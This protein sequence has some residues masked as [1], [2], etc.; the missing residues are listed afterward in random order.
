MGIMDRSSEVQRDLEQ[1]LA[2]ARKR[3]DQ[4][5]EF[6]VLQFPTGFGSSL[7]RQRR[8]DG[9]LE[10]LASL[11]IEVAGVQ[12]QPWE[13]RWTIN[14]HNPRHTPHAFAAGHSG[15]VGAFCGSCG[16]PAL[17]GGQ[18]C[19]SCGAKLEDI[20]DANSNSDGSDVPR[21]ATVRRPTGRLLVTRRK[22]LSGSLF[23]FSV[24]IDGDPCGDLD[25]GQH[26]EIDVELG[27]HI[28]VVQNLNGRAEVALEV[29]A[30]STTHCVVYTNAMGK[31]K[32]ELET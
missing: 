4:G 26:L 6:F 17:P 24:Q 1:L 29:R 12:D 22:K 3:R 20:R 25:N 5:L 18:F 23:S 14:C 11:G 10:S 31:P 19:T 13:Y 21:E 2:R 28:L 30:E 9:A 7:S 32:A 15:Q 16:C 27:Q 8:L